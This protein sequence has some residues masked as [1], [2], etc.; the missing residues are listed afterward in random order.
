M[1]VS[2]TV[3]LYVLMGGGEYIAIFG[4]PGAKIT[5]VPYER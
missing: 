5:W 4:G 2:F 1:V 3:I